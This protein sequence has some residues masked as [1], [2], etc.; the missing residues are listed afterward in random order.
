[1]PK[2]RTLLYFDHND[3]KIKIAA[4]MGLS[5]LTTNHIPQLFVNWLILQFYFAKQNVK[6]IHSQYCF[7]F[8]CSAVGTI[9]QY[10]GNY[11]SSDQQYRVQSSRQGCG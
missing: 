7:C 6:Q 1:M 4:E 10:I 5:C 2:Q 9:C 11:V 8:V 3:D